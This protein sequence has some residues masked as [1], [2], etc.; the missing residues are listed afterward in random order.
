MRENALLG[1]YNFVNEYIRKFEE[2]KTADNF[3]YLLIAISLGAEE[4]YKE[5]LRLG[6]EYIDSFTSQDQLRIYPNLMEMA[7]S[8]GD[9]DYVQKCFEVITKDNDTPSQVF[10]AWWLQ[11]KA[12]KKAGKEKEAEKCRKELLNILPKQNFNEYL[13]KGMER[14]LL[15]EDNKP[16]TIW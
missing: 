13:Y 5:V 10:N 14:H 2:S 11:W 3:N 6:N 4:Q 16:E 8:L 1:N 12:Y 9:L 15:G 7:Y